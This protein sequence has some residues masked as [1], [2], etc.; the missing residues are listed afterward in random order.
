MECHESISN[1]KSISDTGG[2]EKKKRCTYS[3]RLNK[4]HS[5]GRAFDTAITNYKVN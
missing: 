4:F 2:L 5:I 3:L 1:Q